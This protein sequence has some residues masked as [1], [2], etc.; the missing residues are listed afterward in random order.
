MFLAKA[1]SLYEWA[2]AYIPNFVI[3]LHVR[4]QLLHEVE[5][6]FLWVCIAYALFSKTAKN[7]GA[8]TCIYTHTHLQ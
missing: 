4:A 5:R 1:V 8:H 6:G 3:C 2:F 7:D